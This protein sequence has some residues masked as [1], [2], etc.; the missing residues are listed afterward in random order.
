MLTEPSPF[1]TEYQSVSSPSRLAVDRVN[2]RV[3]LVDTGS[4]DTKEQNVK[5]FNRAGKRIGSIGGAPGSGLSARL[6]TSYTTRS[7]R[8]GSASCRRIAGSFPGLRSRK[9]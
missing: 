9:T 2:D 7:A 1:L 8:S 6:I 4:T 5:I 3:Y